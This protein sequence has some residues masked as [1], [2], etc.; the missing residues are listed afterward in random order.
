MTNTSIDSKVQSINITPP[1]IIEIGKKDGQTKEEMPHQKKVSPR[2][3][4][5]LSP[6]SLHRSKNL[7]PFVF[8]NKNKELNE[9]PISKLGDEIIN[10]DLQF[11]LA[12]CSLV[13]FIRGIVLIYFVVKSMNNKNKIDENEHYLIF[14]IT[15]MIFAIV[16]ISTSI[17]GFIYSWMMYMG[18]ILAF[19]IFVALSTFFVLFKLFETVLYEYD[20]TYQF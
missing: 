12:F 4:S 10:E 8:K 19:A 13:Y 1:V 3:K 9:I 11:F 2:S 6:K 18:F 15:D 7:V 5:F 20:R 17:T 16:C 14:E